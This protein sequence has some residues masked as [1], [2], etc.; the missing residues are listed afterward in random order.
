MSGLKW[1]ATNAVH[2]PEV[3]AEHRILYHLAAELKKALLDGAPPADIDESLSGLFAEFEDHFTHEERM[4]RE[5][6]YQLYT[7]HK[8]QHDTARKR[9]RIFAERIRAGDLEAGIQFLEF[10]AGWLRDHIGV[11]DNMMGASIRNFQ[12]LNI[13]KAC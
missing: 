11:A 7:W 12:R 2:L 10:L 4:M 6:H 8:G 1:N 3:D 9:A 13:R 5:A